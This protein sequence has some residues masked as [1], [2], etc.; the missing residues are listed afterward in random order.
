GFDHPVLSGGANLSAGQGQLISFAR[1]VAARTELIVL[2]EATSAVDSVTERLIEEALA[3]LYRDRTVIAIAHRLSTIRKADL[4]LVMDG[5]K[6]VERGRHQEL[7]TLGGVY[8][9]LVSGR[10]DELIVDSA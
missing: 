2:D 5:G 10:H 7:L 4:I 6:I 8:A 9:S 1:A 3:R